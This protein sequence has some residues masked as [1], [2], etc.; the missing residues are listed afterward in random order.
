MI[1]TAKLCG[2]GCASQLCYSSKQKAV[3][4]KTYTT[5]RQK[6][7][8]PCHLT[9][10]C[11]HLPRSG[12]TFR[13]RRIAV[14]GDESCL[15]ASAWNACKFPPATYKIVQNA[16]RRLPKCRLVAAP[17][18]MNFQGNYT[19]QFE[20]IRDLS[21]FKM[22]QGIQRQFTGK[23]FQDKCMKS[24]FVTMYSLRTYD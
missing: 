23:M 22:S 8:S 16:S 2:L 1:S 3:W 24:H 14:S 10:H 15:K 6:T 12:G 21:F 5:S 9:V 11:S 19:L 20:I 7:F 13:T 17:V 4:G 18:C